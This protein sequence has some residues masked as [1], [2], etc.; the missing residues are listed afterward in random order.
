MAETFP[1]EIITFFLSIL[2]IVILALL[3]TIF[4]YRG[5]LISSKSNLRSSNLKINQLNNFMNFFSES[6][7]KTENFHEVYSSI[8]QQIANIT[9]AKN[10]CIYELQND[11]VLIPVGYTKTF[12]PLHI[13]KSFVLSKPLYAT[14]SLKQ[15][16]IKIGEGLIGEIAESRKGVLI[17]DASIDKRLKSANSITPINTLIAIP[18]VS[19][20]ELTGVICAI[21]TKGRKPFSQSNYDTLKSMTKLIVQVHN[22]VKAYSTLAIQQRLSQELEFARLLQTSQLPKEFPDW[23][24]FVIHAYSKSAKEVSGDFYDFVKVDENRLLVIIG[25]ASGKG[26]PACM[27]MAMTRSFISAN[28]G[29]FTNLENMLSELNVNLYRDTTAGRFATLSCCLLNKEEETIEFSRA[30]HTEL[31]CYSSKNLVRKITPHG[32]ALGLLPQEIAGNYDTFSFLFKPYYSILLFS[33]GLTEATDASGQEYG[34]ERLQNI[35]LESCASK[36]SPRK[37]TE[38]IISSI[39]QFSETQEQADDQTLVIISHK[40]AFI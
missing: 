11:D 6:I 31:L 15:E 14:D 18:M 12:P 37:A 4:I 28:V 13:S 5:K 40:K 19:N 17:E 16:K 1:T 2:V 24:P 32:T 8:A 26:I 30:G 35:F 9:E 34:V 36:N 25:D 10:I 33:D 7:T 3:A 23:A 20:D 21:N 22:I 29:R 38:M 27:V 39:D